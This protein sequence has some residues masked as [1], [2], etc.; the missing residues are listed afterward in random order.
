MKGP[1]YTC[2]S[3][4][5]AINFINVAKFHYSPFPFGIWDWKCLWTLAV[6][7]LG[8][9]SG[10]TVNTAP[11]LLLLIKKVIA[12]SVRALVCKMLSCLQ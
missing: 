4:I 11:L 1:V 9:S 3:Y 12:S 6:A 2:D 7:S 10:R 5:L 8:G